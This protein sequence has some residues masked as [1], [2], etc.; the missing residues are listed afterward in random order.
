MTLH[1]TTTAFKSKVAS[2]SRLAPV[3]QKRSHALTGDGLER[4]PG[5]E[6]EAPVRPGHQDPGGRE[7]LRRGV[8]PPEA[9]AH[10]ATHALRPEPRGAGRL[11]R[12]RLL[13]LELT[14]PDPL[15][16]HQLLLFRLVAF[17][18]EDF[19]SVV[20]VS[21]SLFFLTSFIT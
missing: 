16:S 17:T 15:T 13:L 6:V 7:Q 18:S 4:S 14:P 21:P 20:V 1:S 11:L 12:L 3:T 2:L 19:V 10:A 5:Q 8:H 9:G